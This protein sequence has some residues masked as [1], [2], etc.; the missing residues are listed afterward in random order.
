MKH[1]F[2]QNRVLVGLVAGL[3]SE[4]LTGLLLWL[5]LAIASQPVATHGRWFGAIFIPL[6]FILRHYVKRTECNVVVKTLIVILFVTFVGFM[7]VAFG[8]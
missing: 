4:L 8:R 3:G 6:L 2:S 5:G 1:F 7:A